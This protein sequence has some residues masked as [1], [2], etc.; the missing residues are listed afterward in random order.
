MLGRDSRNIWVTIMKPNSIS[1]RELLKFSSLGVLGASAS[2]W[3]E[4]LAARAAADPAAVK[5]C[6]L[7][8]MAGGQSHVDTWDPKPENKSVQFKPIDTSVSGIKLAENLPQLAKLAKEISI[9][10]GMSTNEG[11]HGRARYHLHTGYRQGVGGLI[12]PSLGAIVSSQLGQPNDVLPNFVSIDAKN[13]GRANGSGYIG[14]MHAP[15]EMTDPNKGVENLQSLSGKSDKRTGL[16]EEMEKGF[17]ERLRAPSAEAHQAMYQRAVALMRSPKVKAFDLS[18]E[19]AAMREAYGKSAFGDSCL[20]ARRLVEFGVKFVEI[21]LE[22]WDTHTDNFGMVKQLCGQLD[23]AMSALIKDLKDRG[24]LDSTLVICMSEF[25]RSPNPEGGD[26][27]GHYAKAWSTVMAGAGL[28][29]G[30]IVG[31]TDKLGATVVER[32]ISTV[33]FMATV[34]KA[35]QIDYTKCFTTNEGRPVRIVDKNEK[36]VSELF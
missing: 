5:S 35:L 13:G 29:T 8:F 26:G 7:L 32:P 25:G 4:V 24:R 9:L 22:G 3:F 12:H 19:P 16:L 36:I 34:C 18:Q 10:R 30:Q 28:K 14:P 17:V 1:R 21:T 2:G 6:I 11:D 27:R 15:L 20:L 33:D 31:R 23:P